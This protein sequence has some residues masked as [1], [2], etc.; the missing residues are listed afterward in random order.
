MK[1]E[2]ARVAGVDGCRGGWV[3]AVVPARGRGRSEVFVVARL[4]EV[5]DLD[6]AVL[7]VDMPIGLPHRDRRACDAEARRRIGPR[8]SSV[9]PAPVRAALA[10]W[11]EGASY[12]DTVAA[13]RAASGRGLSRQ[14]FNLLGKIAEVDELVTRTTGRLV[15]AHPE[16]SFAAMAGA[17]LAHA[18]RTPAGAEQRRSLVSEV[19]PDAPARVRGAAPDDLL[20]AYAAA[21]TARRVGAGTAVALG[22]GACDALGLPMRIFV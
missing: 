21:W 10:A 9:F 5:L 20:D 13:S 11:V 22:D 17:T 1:A 12:G 8:R 14:A 7:A 4:A 2:R 15:E 18:K 3:A 19:F 16:A 6:L